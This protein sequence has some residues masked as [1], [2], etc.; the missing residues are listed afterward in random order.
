MLRSTLLRARLSAIVLFL[1]LTAAASASGAEAV[2]GGWTPAAAMSTERYN[3]S[4]ALLPD[5]R[6]L[7][8]G[9]AQS[10]DAPF[11]EIYDPASGMWSPVDGP[12]QPHQGNAILLDS[13]LVLM[14]GGTELNS[15][16]VEEISGRAHLFDP[17]TGMWR[18][19]GSMNSPRD[20][21]VSTRLRDGRIL[22][23]G[24]LRVRGTT[25][26]SAEIYDPLTGAWTPAGEMSIARTGHVAAL[27]R[28]GRVLVAGG[29]YGL[30]GS[31]NG[32]ATS[33][34]Y[35][36]A[37]NAWI[38]T[39]RMSDQR[40]DAVGMTLDDGTVL[41]ASGSYSAYSPHTSAETYD[42]A[43]GEWTLTGELVKGHWAGRAVRLP[44]GRV[45]VAGGYR[46]EATAEVYDPSSRSWS[47]LTPLSTGRSS[48]SLTVLKDGRV[49]VAGGYDGRKYV[50]SVELWSPE[51]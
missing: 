41:I 6:V 36:P 31:Y 24:G 48:H 27:L 12:E 26:A 33:E 1:I 10:A 5:G 42:P 14:A 8:V 18:S 43:T 15:D 16:G 22:V 20:G 28:D 40:A 51:E 9:S 49:L 23:T 34:I 38:M 19:T 30:N 50:A 21:H 29:L 7:V 17:A 47:A 39:G 13:G 35:D 32:I 3:H 11:A 25:D 2:T 4:A 44:D 37:T 45:L 46:G